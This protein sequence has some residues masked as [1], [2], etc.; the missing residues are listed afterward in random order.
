MSEKYATK[1]K[2]DEFWPD[3]H[4]LIINYIL[5]SILQPSENEWWIIIFLEKFF[6]V[7]YDGAFQF[8]KN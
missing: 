7:Y 2:K 3:S 4:P 1:R 6:L 8:K 5:F